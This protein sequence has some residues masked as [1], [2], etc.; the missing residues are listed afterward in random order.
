MGSG[1]HQ[2]PSRLSTFT[3]RLSPFPALPTLPA[4]NAR[5]DGAIYSVSF[6]NWRKA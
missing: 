2:A 5:L 1:C 6:Q 3:N 4:L